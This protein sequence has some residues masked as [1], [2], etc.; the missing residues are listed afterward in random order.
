LI[1]NR[2][3]SYPQL[4]IEQAS[5]LIAGCDHAGLVHLCPL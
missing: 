2:R 3:I 5:R 4:Q 1:G